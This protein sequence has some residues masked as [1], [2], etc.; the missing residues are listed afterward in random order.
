MANKRLSLQD[1]EELKK[2]VQTGVAPEDIANHFGMAI[3]SVHN[4][5]KKFK[6]EGMTFPSMRGK[7]P[8][9]SVDGVTSTPSQPSRPVIGQMGTPTMQGD[10]YKFIV[11]G[12]SV[13]ISGQAKNVNIGKDHMEINF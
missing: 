10:N 9:G 3:S 8:V 13:Q 1:V 7:R 2:M 12:V 5:K 11:N 4:Y 6:A